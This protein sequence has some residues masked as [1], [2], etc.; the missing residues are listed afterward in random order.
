MR[1]ARVRGE[2]RLERGHAVVGA[3]G[4]VVAAELDEGIAD[5]AVRPGGRRRE[6]LRTAA[7]RERLVEAVPHERER[8]EPA[9]RVEVAGIAGQRPAERALGAA[10]VG[11]VGRLAR[12]A[13]RRGRAARER[14]RRPSAPLVPQAQHLRLRVAGREARKSSRRAPPEPTARGVSRPGRRRARRRARL[15]RSAGLDRSKSAERGGARR[16]VSPYGPGPPRA[17]MDVLVA[18]VRLP[19][20]REVDLE[21]AVVLVHAVAE[22]VVRRPVGVAAA[23][24]E[25]LDQRA[26]GRAVAARERAQVDV[27]TSSSS[28]RPFGK[29]AKSPARTP[30]RLPVPTGPVGGCPCSA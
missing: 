6:A 10:V 1:D 20:V 9:Q 27:V 30:S 22:Q 8:A 16:A 4:L 14:G 26:D 17:V 5:H 23:L 29:P 18:L 13:G 3:E 2:A 19:D 21:R 25:A 15:A 24:T 11:G 28:R 12:A 7:Q